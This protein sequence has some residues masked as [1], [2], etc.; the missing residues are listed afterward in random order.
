MTLAFEV[1]LDRFG[2]SL[3]ELSLAPEDAW[4]VVQGLKRC[5]GGTNGIAPPVAVSLRAAA[6]TLSVGALG[7]LIPGD[8]V[9]A[10]SESRPDGTAVVVIGDHLVAPAE[11]GPTGSL[12]SGRPMAGRGSS[13]EWSMD[14]RTEGAAAV[15]LEDS[16]LEDLPVRI[17]F[18]LG[19]VELPLGEIRRL[20]PG[21][22]IPLARAFD[23]P[24]DIVA[25]G[26]RLGR[27]ALVRIGHNL[28]VR[29]VS[30][31]GND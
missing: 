29:I 18:E 15:A 14:N 13:W 22:L 7:R 6:A 1:A 12:L 28:G 17:V 30:L 26:R 3:C 23:E 16:E 25:N 5:A 11:V 21:A 2:S 8:V 24:L 31:V 20:A 10:D 27:G 19:R 4:R 9:L